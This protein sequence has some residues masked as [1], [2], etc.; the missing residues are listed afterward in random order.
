MTDET[1]VENKPHDN[2]VFLVVVDDS[3]E[4]QVALRFACQRAKNTGG[5]VALFTTIEPS[6]FVHWMGV[7]EIMREEAR[8]EAELLVNDLSNSVVEISGQIPAIYVR[9]GN[10]R[11]ELMSL[12][13]EEPSISILVL[14]ANTGSEGPGPL[15]SY[16]VGKA[17]GKIGIP[18]TI[19]PGNLTDEQID[20][21]T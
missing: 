18:V 7:G 10:P 6:D 4:M 20:A 9:E 21:L 16:L 8:E 2:R 15:V 17:A 12:I 13:E 5:R 14:G 11:D 19:V 1:N 3:E